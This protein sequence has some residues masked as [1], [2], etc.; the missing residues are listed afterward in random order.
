MLTFHKLSPVLDYGEVSV[1]GSELTIQLSFLLGKENFSPGRNLESSR[2]QAG[3]R[4]CVYACTIGQLAHINYA[5]TRTRR[6][7][8]FGRAFH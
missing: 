4:A 7:I 5:R 6:P 2:A 1:P 3:Q 8:N